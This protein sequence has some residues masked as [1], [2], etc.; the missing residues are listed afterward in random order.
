MSQFFDSLKDLISPDMI[1]KAALLLG[2]KDTKVSGAISSIIPGLLASFLK[3]GDNP[4]TLSTLEEAGK[5]NILS[6]LSRLFT[7]NESAEQQSIGDKFLHSLMGNKTPDFISAVA[8]HSDISYLNAGKLTSMIA[9]LVASFLGNKLSSG[10]F[11][12]SGLIGELSKEKGSFLSAIPS[13]VTDLLNLSSIFGTHTPSSTGTTGH[14]S[15]SPANKKNNG[16]IKW[17]LLA[18]LVLLLFFLWRSC[19]SSSTDETINAVTDKTSEIVDTIK[20]KT[21]NIVNDINEKISTELTLPDGVKLHAYKNGIEDQIITFLNSDV[22]KNA[23]PDQLR[24]NWFNFDNIE[25]VHG[26]ATELTEASYPQ[27][28]NISSILKYYKDVKVKIGGYTDKTG[29]KEANLKLSQERANT[30]KSILEKNG[31]S[32]KNIS[33]EGYGDQFA[34]HPA[35]ASDSDRALDRKIA[36]R[37]VK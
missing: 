14:N 16:W 5:S 4:Q 29:S 21:T 2:E 1:S 11:S 9:P 8:S 15:S 12:L 26:S 37:F 23:T 18:L 30:I 22:Y 32:A 17:V 27:L 6:E 33:A 3:S 36:L 28:N 13:G 34:T 31:V 19:R 25:F 7:G 24:D 10:N 20:N 35:D